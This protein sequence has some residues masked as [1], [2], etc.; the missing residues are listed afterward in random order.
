MSVEVVVKF[1]GS[2]ERLPRF[3]EICKNLSESLRGHKS[4]VVPGGGKFADV[5][6][7]C[8]RQWKLAAFTSHWMAVLA[9]DQFGYVLAEKVPHSVTAYGK[10]DISKAWLSGKIPIF[11]PSSWLKEQRGIPE[12]WETTSDS[13][14][15]FIATAFG[16][17]RLVLLKDNIP[18]YD[19]KDLRGTSWVDPMFFRFLSRY[20]GEVWLCDGSKKLSLQNTVSCGDR[21]CFRL[22]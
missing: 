22:Q 9:M 3:L 6:R 17:S 13:L 14:A 5:V 12:S 8:D 19:V 15:C 4:I 7:L 10:E 2:L 18:P 20:N 16:A 1:G 11:L 21:C